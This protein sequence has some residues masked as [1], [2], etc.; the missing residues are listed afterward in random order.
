MIL[1]IIGIGVG[2]IGIVVTC[3]GIGQAM[4]KSESTNAQV[5]VQGDVIVVM[6]KDVIIKNDKVKKAIR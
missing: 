1:N 3:V 5:I 6:D 4:K 2:I